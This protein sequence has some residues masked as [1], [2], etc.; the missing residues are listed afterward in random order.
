[1]PLFHSLGIE[2]VTACVSGNYFFAGTLSPK[3]DAG[4]IDMT[5]K[6]LV[7]VKCE[8]IPLK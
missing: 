8:A 2:T 5:R 6:F 1:M 4:N 7:F 3:D